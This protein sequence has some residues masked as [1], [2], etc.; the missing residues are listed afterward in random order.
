[1]GVPS[2][3]TA[4]ARLWGD[5]EVQQKI[6][7]ALHHPFVRALAAGELPREAFQ[8]Y[9]AEDAF[10][11]RSFAEGY[12][13]AMQRCGPQQQHLAQALG[14]LLTG[15]QE[16][17]KL[18]DSYAA[19]WGVDLSQHQQPLP[20]TR[21]Y[22][23]WLHAI[24]SDPQQGVAGIVSA[25]VPCLRLYA[26]LALQLAKAFPEADHEYTEWVRSYSSPEYL[27]LPGK[28]EAVLDE[29]APSESFGEC[30]IQMHFWVQAVGA[31]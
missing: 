27:R 19:E 25:M 30:S 6:L 9:I 21:A 16:E 10:F 15:V 4:S 7:G 22:I 18:H 28:A 29:T 26:Y 2:P 8:S 12:S 31:S 24:A 17:L 3:K 20:A 5:Q 14:E 23:E 1:M 11:L 13:A